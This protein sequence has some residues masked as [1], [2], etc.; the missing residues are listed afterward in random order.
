MTE[1][2]TWE[3]KEDLE[4]ARKVLEEFE[5][6]MNTEVRRQEKLDRIEENDFK[7]GELPGRFIVKML[8]G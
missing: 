6:R 5:G 7:R 2:N 1:N 3:R 8:Y 4:N